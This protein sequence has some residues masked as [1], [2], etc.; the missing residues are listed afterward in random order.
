[1]PADIDLTQLFRA[2][3][4]RLFAIAY[5]MLGSVGDAED[6]VQETFLRYQRSAESEPARHPRTLLATIATRLAIDQ[7]RSSRHRRE[8]YI[9]PWI[10]EPLVSNDPDAAD[11]V[12]LAESLSLAFLVVLETLSP[13]ERAV[14]LLREAFD[15]DYDAIAGI[16][17]RTPANCRQIAARARR[18]I[19]A[20]R[21]RF[22]ASRDARDALARRFFA[23]CQDGDTEALLALLSADCVTYGDGGGRAPAARVPI[24]GRERAARVLLGLAGLGRR[25]GARPEL[26]TV[27]GQPGARFLT[28][29]GRLINVVALD[30]ADAR[31][32]TVRSIVNPDKLRHLGPLADVGA[33]LSQLAGPRPPT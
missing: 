16:V 15:Y 23:A 22:E 18:H 26:V 30:I 25:V 12:E 32:H 17:E 5:R 9:G 20:R 7:L 29:D 33:L 3:R 2:E 14:Y 8:Q 1:M 13:V 6:V 4:Q 21:P 28:P 31:V 24:R 27:N 11:Q 19:E 10:P